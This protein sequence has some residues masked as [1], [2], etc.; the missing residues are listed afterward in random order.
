MDSLKFASL[1]Q[2]RPKSDTENRLEDDLMESPSTSRNLQE[3]MGK[4][5]SHQIDM[6]KKK[7]PDTKVR[8]S[9]K[10]EIMQLKKLLKD[11]LA[12]RHALEKALGY[13]ANVNDSS[14]IEVIIPLPAKELIREIA[15]LELEVMHLEQYLLS[16]YRKAFDQQVTIASP[17]V[18]PKTRLKAPI[19]CQRMLFQVPKPEI[20]S[21]KIPVVNS[22]RI[23]PSQMSA[24]KL[25][26]ESCCEN[27][28]NLSINR[29]H[30]ALNH[31]AVYSTRISPSEEPMPFLKVTNSSLNIC[32]DDHG[33]ISGVISLAEYLGTS[34]ADH[35]PETP[36]K[37]SED[38]VRCMGAIYSK[39]A[40]P[41]L[42]NN[43]P[44]S[45]PA[46]SLSSMSASSP[47]YIGDVWSP[48]C[49][50]ES[51]LDIRLINP[52]RIEGLKEFSG[53]Y[54][55]MV[56]VSSINRDSQRFKI[57][58]DLLD[59]YKSL[60]QKLATVDVSKMKND[61]KMPFWINLHNALMMHAYLVHGVPPSSLKRTSLL[62]KATCIVG[63]HSVNAE[64][65]QDSFLG[66]RTRLSGQWLQTFKHPRIKFKARDER[67]RF[68]AIEKKEPLLH[69]ALCSGSHSD[70][71]VRI[72]TAK[73]LYQQL[74]TAKEE[75]I[76]AT[77]GVLRE[78]KVLLPKLIESYTK[79]ICVSSQKT[80]DMI[81]CHLPETMRIA[82]QRCQRGRSQK[83]IQWVPHNF[84]FR[85]LL[86]REVA[87][88]QII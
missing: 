83:I 71:A 44:V 80:V 19:S 64:M 6:K 43:G 72:Y 52:Y 81:Q 62:V 1:R 24:N 34:I 35:V 69:F 59:T 38:M 46:S 87:N 20:S 65:I 33:T 25:A 4:G 75:Y 37:I 70:P 3:E 28:T 61:E 53:P 31:R 86:S 23:L 85:Y 45:S 73:R 15:V 36:N 40:D 12:V 16:L 74:E 68:Y 9:L 60:V 66:C 21:K 55:A 48:G 79:D 7:L 50:N 14:S 10:Q 22:T 39:L 78:K 8:G 18:P 76:R 30:S 32:Q 88:P 17:A 77:V 49:K 54:N 82:V 5:E 42:V 58:G 11:Q 13:K 56:E 41:L 29:S 84:S 57:T 27:L 26:D 51:N 67:R 47:Q 2:K 63:G